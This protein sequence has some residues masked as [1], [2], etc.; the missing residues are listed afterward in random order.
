MKEA[1]VLESSVG[2][3][4]WK[5]TANGGSRRFVPKFKEVSTICP[6]PVAA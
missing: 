1:S 2:K 4:T 6:Q 3:I 5:N